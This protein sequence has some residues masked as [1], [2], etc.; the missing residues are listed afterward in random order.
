[1]TLEQLL[2]QLGLNISSSFVYDVVKSYFKKETNHTVEGLKAEL[3]SRLNIEGADI[4][5]NNIINFLAENGDITISG[6]QIYASKSITMASSQGTKFTF[7]NNSKSTTDKSSIEAGHG[8][9]IQG[10]GGARIV[11]DE[12]GS[13]KFYT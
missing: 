10:Q 11:Q 13:I 2:I 1:M 5:S 8:A 7:G 4:K 9:Q 6:T 3:S 12:D